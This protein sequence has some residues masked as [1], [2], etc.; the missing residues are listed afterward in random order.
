M[1][2]TIA[3]LQSKCDTLAI[4]CYD[5][6]GTSLHSDLEYV[7]ADDGT[8]TCWT[9]DKEPNA[10]PAAYKFR[11][12]VTNSAGGNVVWLHNLMGEEYFTL[13]AN[14]AYITN[15]VS[16]AWSGSTSSY[17]DTQIVDKTDPKFYLPTFT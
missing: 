14:C 12:K 3:S 1:L 5:E 6:T 4:E 13:K 17:S 10:A 11:I 16:M 7:L 2:K 9:K 8:Q 15:S